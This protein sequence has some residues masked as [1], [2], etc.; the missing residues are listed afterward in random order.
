MERWREKSDEKRNAMKISTLLMHHIAVEGIEL[1]QDSIKVKFRSHEAAEAF[2]NNLREELNKLCKYS[3]DNEKIVIEKK[4]NAETFES[5]VSAIKSEC[6]RFNS[7]SSKPRTAIKVRNLEAER[8]LRD[9]ASR[10]SGISQELADDISELIEK[11]NGDA[12]L[13]CGLGNIAMYLSYSNKDIFH[14]AVKILKEVKYDVGRVAFYLG[15]NKGIPP[16]EFLDLLDIVNIN[17]DNKDALWE[18]CNDLDE[19]YHWND[20]SAGLREIKRKYGGGKYE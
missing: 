6:E 20:I 11:N 18:L 13:I 4:E 5:I 9:F 7:I 1:R 19:L 14:A 2:S 12:N 17:K 10:G 16:W 8:I 3:S 15:M